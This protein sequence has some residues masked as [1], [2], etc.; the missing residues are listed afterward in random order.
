MDVASQWAVEVEGFTKRYR[1]GWSADSVAAVENISFRVA[2]G[3][4]LGIFGPNGSGKSTTLRALAGLLRASSGACRIC[5]HPA[6]GDEARARVGYLPEVVRLATHL[7][8]REFLRFCAA[9]SSLPAFQADRRVDAVLAWSG[10]GEAS[11]RAIG[12]YSKGLRQR[13]GLAQAIL[14]D[15]VVVL[16]D[17]PASGLD[18]EGRLAVVRLIRALADEGRAVVFTSHLLAQAEEVC[19]QI[20]VFAGGRMLANGPVTEL[21]GTV[22][23]RAPLAPSRLEQLYLEK[24]HGAA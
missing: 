20:A 5:G 23:S 1:R 22:P 11:E 6:G 4:V 14:H 19:D 13:L 8:G 16:L 10:L 15:P 18:P 7:S 12:T 9:M 21:L 3:T 17:E 24:L 2:A